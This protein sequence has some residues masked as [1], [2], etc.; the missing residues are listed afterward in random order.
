MKL[1]GPIRRKRP[2]RAKRWG[3]RPNPEKRK[4]RRER[5]GRDD[6]DYLAFV[7]SLRCCAYALSECD[8]GLSD[9]HHAGRRPGMGLKCHDRETI[10][11]CRLHHQAIERDHAPFK[12]WTK[13]QRLAWVDARIR[14]TQERF[15]DRSPAE[16]LA[17]LLE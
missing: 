6:P 3:I 7:R 1:G 9:P 4:S 11:M 10:P 15:A 16:P 17:V 13:A 2:L 5:S 12:G 8:G 14:E